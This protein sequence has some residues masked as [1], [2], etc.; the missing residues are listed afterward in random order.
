MRFR[1]QVQSRPL[2]V[3][4]PMWVQTSEAVSLSGVCPWPLRV[5][6]GPRDGLCQR[7]V[8]MPLLC[9]FGCIKC[10]CSLRVIPGLVWFVYRI[11]GSLAETSAILSSSM[12]LFTGSSVQ[13]DEVYSV[14][15]FCGLCS[16]KWL[17]LPSGKAAEDTRE[18]KKKIT[19]I[20]PIL[21][22]Q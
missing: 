11:R 10:V 5:S 22:S 14:L 20:P 8:L 17:G 7:S 4:V 19:W 12:S 18:G 16:Y 3:V 1:L 2:S 15:S 21:F 13:N 9:F 6:V